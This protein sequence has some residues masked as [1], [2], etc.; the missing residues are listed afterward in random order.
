MA[1]SIDRPSER[2]RVALEAC[3]TVSS[4]RFRSRRNSMRVV[5]G[6]TLQCS[7]A[8]EKACR[9]LQPVNGVD[10]LKTIFSRLGRGAIEEQDEA[11]QRLSRP[12]RERPAIELNDRVREL[13]AVRFQMTLHTYLDLPAGSESRRIHDR[14]GDRLD[15]RPT[16]LGETNVRAARTMTSLAIDAFRQGTCEMRFGF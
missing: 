9:H 15:A 3:G 4:R 7:P 5:A 6:G 12:V 10:D 11:S 8:F 14:L 1:A 13:H 16:T 2:S